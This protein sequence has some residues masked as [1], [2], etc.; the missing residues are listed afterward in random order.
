M[1]DE[2]LTPMEEQQALLKAKKEALQGKQLRQAGLLSA[3]R[4]GDPEPETSKLPLWPLLLLL[5]LVLIPLRPKAR[6][7]LPPPP[8]NISLPQVVFPAGVTLFYQQTLREEAQLCQSLF[9]N[10]GIQMTLE[11]LVGPTG[12]NALYLLDGPHAKRWQEAGLLCPLPLASDALPLWAQIYPSLWGPLLVGKKAWALPLCAAPPFLFIQKEAWRKAGLGKAQIPKSWEEVLGLLPRLTEF[13]PDGRPAQIPFWP[14]EESPLLWAY[15][16]DSNLTEKALKTAA[17]WLGQVSR[18]SLVT[19]PKDRRK[20][21]LVA[22]HNSS[23]EYYTALPPTPSGNPSF[24][25]S[26]VTYLALAQGSTLAAKLPLIYANFDWNL[27]Q[28]LLPPV[29]GKVSGIELAGLMRATALFID[30]EKQQNLILSIYRDL[31][32]IGKE[33]ASAGN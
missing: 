27:P 25:V 17:A 20:V 8:L 22:K 15:Q 26:E 16:L 12:A 1:S 30:P 10:L 11:P 29:L 6:T 5:P 2:K 13:D 7:P 18:Q 31:E 32:K 14:F 4:L 3:Q 23:D 24:L 28:G 9:E 33:T 21:M 19:T